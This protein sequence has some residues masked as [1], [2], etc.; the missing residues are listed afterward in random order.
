MLKAFIIGWVCGLVVAIPPGPLSTLTIVTAAGQ[1]MRSAVSIAA[2]GM[3]VEFAYALVGFEGSQ[4]LS[5]VSRIPEVRAVPAVVLLVF[6]ARAILSAGAVKIAAPIPRIRMSRGLLTGLVMAVGSPTIAGGYVV[7]G[8][9]AER[10]TGY[11]FAPEEIFTA[12]VGAVA[13]SFSWIMILISSTIVLC[14]RARPASLSIVVR[15]G[16]LILI[17]A[18]VATAIDLIRIWTN[19]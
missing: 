8:Q 11:S 10:S 12:A 13:G 1:G 7:L 14:G 5:F 3:V 18:G 19:R 16:G 4:Y 9:A 2:G 15:A 17:T 6:G